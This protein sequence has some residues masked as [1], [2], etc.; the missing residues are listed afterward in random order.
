MY[1]N[2]KML[3][4]YLEYL[5]SQDVEENWYSDKNTSL[6]KLQWNCA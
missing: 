1:G 4:L 6:F 3:S 5:Q 2:R